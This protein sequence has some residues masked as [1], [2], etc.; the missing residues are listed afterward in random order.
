MEDVTKYLKS[1]K[2]RETALKDPIVKKL[3]SYVGFGE[4]W[5]FCQ[6]DVFL[7]SSINKFRLFSLFFEHLFD[8]FHLEMLLLLLTL[9]VLVELSVCL[10]HLAWFNLIDF[11]TS[12]FDRLRHY[13]E[14]FFLEL[15]QHLVIP[16][17]TLPL[18][19][20]D[21]SFTD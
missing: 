20:L 13:F 15:G 6:L 7:H 16:N 11:D 19:V 17:R 8:V 10:F 2:W 18:V 14:S 12:V 5:L 1:F 3:N 4:D 21:C 9:F